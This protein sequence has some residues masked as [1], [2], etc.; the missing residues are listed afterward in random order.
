MAVAIPSLDH[1]PVGSALGPDR[2]G[3]DK[4]GGRL[5]VVSNRVPVPSGAGSPNAGGLAVALDAALK[6]RGGLWFGWS[7]ATVKGRE[8][9]T[10]AQA[11][12]NVEYAVSDLSERDLEDFY[13]GFAN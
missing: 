8:P 1:E 2:S 5:V 6:Q 3:L 4:A 11:F 7:G 10:Q 13:H 12:G 9:E